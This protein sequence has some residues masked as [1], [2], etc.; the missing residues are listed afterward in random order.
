MGMNKYDRLF[1]IINLLRSRKN[2]NA[3]A[4]AKECGVTERSIYRDIIALSESNVPIYYDNGYKLASDCFLPPLN[5]E[6]NEYNFLRIALE[7]SPLTE[8]AEYADILQKIK[9]KIDAGLSTQVRQDTKF[10]PQAASVNV[11]TSF[12]PERVSEYIAELEKAIIE[13]RR[14]NLIYDSIN[15]GVTERLID[16]YFIVFRGRAFYFVGFCHRNNNIRTFRLDRI[17]AL[18]TTDHTFVRADDIDAATYFEGSWEVYSGKRVTVKV[19]LTGPAARV[20]LSGQ[21][22]PNEEIERI[23]RDEVI[24]VVETR[25]IEEI[26]RWI[27]GFGA[28]AEVIEPTE[29]KAKLAGVGSYLSDT[30]GKSR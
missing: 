7:S 5:L 9:A 3:A 6:L 10:T 25:G 28:D 12:D 27:L 24:Y 1:H 21:H 2:L 30:Y 20:V 16:P 23:S 8:T 4:L 18:D 15:S 17:K 13:S 22:H 11:H 19:R 29:L 26:G 14:M